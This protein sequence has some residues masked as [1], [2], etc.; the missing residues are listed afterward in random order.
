MPY[1]CHNKDDITQMLD[2]IGIKSIDDLFTNIPAEIRCDNL[3]IDSG[4]DE[5]QTSLYIKNIA[6]KNAS[7]IKNFAGGGAYHH[8]IPSAVWQIASRGEFY[9]SYTPYQAEC[10]QGTLQTIYEF[11]S[12]I[13]A[14]T[15]MDVSNAS[16]YDGASATAEAVLMAKRINKKNKNSKKVL[17]P[18]ALN[19]AYINVIK[20]TIQN[21]GFEIELLNYN[22]KTGTTISPQDNQADDVFALIIPQPN[23]FGNLEDIDNLTNWAH[24]NNIIVIAVVNPISLA[25]LKPPAKWGE[26]GAD[27]TTGEAQSL[28]VPLSSGGPYLGFLACKKEF[29]RQMPG[30][31]V[32]QTTDEYGKIGY[33]LTLQAREQHIRRSKATS[34]ICT[35]QGLMATAAT[36]F[37]SLLGEDGMIKLAQQNWQQSH[38]LQQI[39]QQNKYIKILWNAPF[40]NEFV[41]QI[42]DVITVDDLIKSVSNHNIVMGIKLENNYPNLKN[43][44]LITATEMTTC[45]DMR[46]LSDTINENIKTLC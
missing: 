17:I 18:Q 21:Q 37:L 45:D 22:E 14:L 11:Q 43:C 23:Y 32:G 10:S 3:N 16:L 6:A 1:I 44:L 15:A 41:I 12:M 26:S 46:I 28:G 31:I 25:I 24:Q 33:V 39:L 29:I 34:N 2:D 35:N 40:F 9:T 5:M 7:N 27:I 13:C 4:K 30:R 38:Q 8:Y 42:D 36:I 20:T 19:P